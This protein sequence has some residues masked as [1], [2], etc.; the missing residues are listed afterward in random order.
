[1]EDAWITTCGRLVVFSALMNQKCCDFRDTE[2]TPIILLSTLQKLI[3]Y[4][5]LKSESETTGQFYLGKIFETT[6]LDMKVPDFFAHLVTLNF[7]TF[8]TSSFSN[9]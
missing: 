7:Q 4:T 9:Q 8:R 6:T 5:L 2:G 3:L 1:M